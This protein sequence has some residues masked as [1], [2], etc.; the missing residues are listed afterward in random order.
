MK[1]AVENG[2]ITDI[3]SWKEVKHEIIDDA[4]KP[5]GS[6]RRNILHRKRQ[7]AV[8]GSCFYRWHGGSPDG[9]LRAGGEQ[10]DQ[11]EFLRI[12]E[13]SERGR[14][15]FRDFGLRISV[16]TGDGGCG[17]HGGI[18][19]VDDP[20]GAKSSFV[21]ELQLPDAI[22]AGSLY[23]GP[24]HRDDLVWRI[25][26]LQH[27]APGFQNPDPGGHRPVLAGHVP[28]PDC[29]FHRVSNTGYV[30]G[31]QGT[32]G[33]CKARREAGDAESEGGHSRDQGGQRTNHKGEKSHREG[34]IHDAPGGTP[35]LQRSGGE[36]AYKNK[37]E[38]HKRP[39][40]AGRFCMARG[41]RAHRK[42]KGRKRKK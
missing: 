30:D 11:Y 7:R 22:T 36:V 42:L 29:P 17:N 31:K 21:G 9:H 33:G 16:R 8:C 23:G 26:V 5:A 12:E 18:C 38:M 35:S 34:R 20:R 37:Y 14:I 19:P 4:C 3:K 40:S 27:D 6:G 41:N 1:W 15:Y 32:P 13:G 2:N 10:S 25:H 24:G 39:A 28:L